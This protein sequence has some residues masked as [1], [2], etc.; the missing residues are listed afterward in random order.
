MSRY[1]I[2]KYYKIGDGKIQTP[3]LFEGEKLYVPY[4]WEL[5]LAGNAH[6]VGSDSMQFSVTPKDRSMFPELGDRM[7]VILRP[8]GNKIREA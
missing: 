3:G 2:L 4:F 6:E 5:Y 7:V 8:D 1:D